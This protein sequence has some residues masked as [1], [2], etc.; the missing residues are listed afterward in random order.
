VRHVLAVSDLSEADVD[1]VVQRAADLAAGASPDRRRPLIATMFLSSSVRTRV[2]FSAAAARLG[3]SVVDASE[4]RFGPEMSTSESFEDAVRVVSGM[5][6]AIVV[7]VPFPLDRDTVARVAQCPVVNAGDEGGEHP[8]QALVDLAAVQRYAGPVDGLRVGLCGDLGMRAVSSLLRLLERRPPAALR[9]MAPAGRGPRVDLGRLAGLAEPSPVRFDGLDVLY[10]PGL[11]E[12]GPGGA[13]DREQR[14]AYALTGA[15]LAE[16]DAGAVVLSPLPVID[17][18]DDVARADERV[19]MFE[20]SDHGVHV[21]AAL[22][23]LV[24]DDGRSR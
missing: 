11:P 3:G 22:L 23:E 17:E 5:V 12:R 10:L 20:Q 2:G 14:A 18:I 21:R 8:S 4:L 6:D 13:L 19:R 1:R 16:L 9:L 7:R 15:R 24:L